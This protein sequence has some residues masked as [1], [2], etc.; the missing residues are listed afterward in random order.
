MRCLGPNFSGYLALYSTICI[1]A[2]L[3]LASAAFV[4][5][6]H[7]CKSD[8]RVSHCPPRKMMNTELMTTCEKASC[9]S[10]L[11]VNL[12]HLCCVVC[13]HQLYLVCPLRLKGYQGQ[14]HHP[15][16]MENDVEFCFLDHHVRI[17]ICWKQIPFRGLVGRTL[18]SLLS[19]Y[20]TS[21]SPTSWANDSKLW[22]ISTYPYLLATPVYNCLTLWLRNKFIQ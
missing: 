6:Q 7:F 22:S 3:P 8:N 19:L 18:K 14:S 10:L 13:T 20:Y 21:L 2:Q 5:A 4:T 17:R 9:A 16:H 15:Q 11:H 1:Q 12:W